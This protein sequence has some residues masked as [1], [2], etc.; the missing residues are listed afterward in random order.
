MFEKASRLKLRFESPKGKL[1]V[2]DLWDLPLT[3]DPNR[4]S[5]KEI[6]NLDDIAKAVNKQLKEL[7]DDSFVAK[8]PKAN[9]VLQLRLD[10]LKYII[11]VRL[12]ET[13]AASQAASRREQQDKILSLIAQKQDEQLR[14]KTLDELQAMVKS[15]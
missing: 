7:E 10:I 9:A 3:A 2:E 13:E 12:A 11:S 6:A 14:S 4:A 1:S 8:R 5:A 15:L